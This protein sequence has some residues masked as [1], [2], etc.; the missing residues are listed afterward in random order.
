MKVKNDA[1]VKFKV[2]LDGQEANSQ[3]DD[4]SKKSDLAQK[5]LSKIGSIGKTVFKSLAAGVTIAGGAL[6]TLV[7]KSVSMAGELEQQIGG[8]EAVFKE[9]AATVQSDAK[10]AY[11]VM[12]LSANDYMA[13]INKM[14][15]LMQGSGLDV[16][17]SMDLSS[18]AMQRAADVA[19]IM[20]IDTSS[21]MESIAGAAK[22]N[23]TMMDNLGVA[24]N[25]TTIESYALSKGI[26][27]SYDE[28]T[29]AQK[30]ELAM[31]MFLEKTTYATKNYEKENDTFA[32]SFSTLKA[33]VENF[34]SGAGD[35]DAVID[36][37]MSFSKILVNS[38][39]KMAPQ[40]VQGI[41]S[42]INGIVP[43]LPTILQ[44]LLPVIINGAISL[45]QGLIA[46][47]PSIIPVLL[48]GL[49]QALMGIVQI[50]PD[51][52]QML[53][54]LTIQVINALAEQLPTLLPQIIDAILQMIP[55][56]LD[57]LP[58]IIEAG[59]QLLLGLIQGIVESI[60]LLIE[61]LPQ[62]IMSIT[63]TLI[64]LLP[65]I[66]AIGPQIILTLVTGL[67]NSLP[68]LVKSIPKLIT[69]M[70]NQF[71]NGLGK[72]LTVGK[73]IIGKLWKGISDAIV[74]VLEKIPGF[75]KEI[76]QKI[77][78]GFESI[79]DI[80]KNLV[81]GLWNGINNAKDW[82]LDKIKGFGKSVLNGIKDFFGIHSPS[83]VMFE[84]GGYFDEGFINGVEDMEKDVTKQVNSTFGKG[85]EYLYN[86]Y[87][88]FDLNTPDVSNS[89]LPNQTIYIDNK[90]TNESVL[91]V[92]RQVLARVVNEV[93]NEREV[94]V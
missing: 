34:L 83:K 66:L 19:S 86:G 54:E 82:V 56:L 9:Y 70:V 73:E 89:Y 92:D 45:I 59:I 94:A 60:P 81:K 52:L 65:E 14:G 90:N 48:E 91:K 29:N 46:A 80:G 57:N 53:L 50:L 18:Q 38:I 39:S 22:G 58:L 74:G 72:F 31:Q 11:S 17:K 21:A 7:G 43:Q 4:L 33:S 76:L 3:V 24:M 20:G 5:S 79:D 62:I 40:I 16:K 75:P 71:F 26:K 55:M 49:I 36:N 2:V 68:D 63:S 8:T 27:T 41:I 84:I 23:F 25:A 61:M 64:S 85:L 10:K 51:L 13:T 30:V 67:I 12:G 28:M 87:D 37:V 77:K 69:G 32:G 6:T 78:N 35:I 88:N 93:N 15:S 42:L 47:L 44:T 1:E